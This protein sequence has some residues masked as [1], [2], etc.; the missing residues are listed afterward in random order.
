MENE[1]Q[2]FKCGEVRNLSDFYKNPQ[3]SD[4]HVN[5]C[6]ECNKRDVRENRKDKVEY[7]RE[8]DSKRSM[9][10]QRV[11]AR[12][13]YQSTENG[14]RAM[15]K[16]RKNWLEKNPIKRAA[17]IM[18][19]NAVRDGRLYKNKSCESCGQSPKRLHGHHDDYAYPLQVRWL[20]QKC[21]SA[22][23]KLNGE[24]KNAR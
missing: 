9:V 10:P 20:C 7:Y 13:I 6:K 24:G 14:K 16:A 4:G 19:G 1:K 12:M 18:V 3:M 17:Q 15:L 8:Y 11:E 2:C 21:H 5:K 22:W 23:H